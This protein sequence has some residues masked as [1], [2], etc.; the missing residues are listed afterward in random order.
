MRPQKVYSAAIPYFPKRNVDF[1][2]SMQKTRALLC[3]RIEALP[4]PYPM[5]RFGVLI[6]CGAKQAIFM[7]VVAL[8]LQ[9]IINAPCWVCA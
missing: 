7:P 5:K 3:K 4:Y 8:D 6:A 1:L 9:L 2:A